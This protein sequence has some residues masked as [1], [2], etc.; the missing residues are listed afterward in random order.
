MQKYF[1]KGAFYADDAKAQGLDRREIMGAKFAD[2]VDRELLPKSLQMRDMTKIGKR[3]ATKYK[4]LKSED[5]GSWGRFDDRGPRK[6]GP[7]GFGQDERFM[8]DRDR[9]GAAG[10]SGA[11]SMPV[12]ERKREINAP[13]GPKSMRSRTEGDNYRPSNRE[14]RD[15][16]RSSSPRRDKGQDHHRRKRSISR[17]RPYRDGDKRR[18]VDER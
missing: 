11:N 6:G 17:E 4:D 14:D 8:P 1:H 7:G 13:E 2:D 12:T 5:T 16:S 18:R 9:G 10:G 3:G 15:R